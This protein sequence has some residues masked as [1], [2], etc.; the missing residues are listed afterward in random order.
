MVDDGLSSGRDVEGSGKLYLCTTSTWQ[1]FSYSVFI[2]FKISDKLSESYNFMM[3][4]AKFLLLLRSR[5][6]A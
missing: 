5:I 2:L 6:E 4:C 3:L 1:T